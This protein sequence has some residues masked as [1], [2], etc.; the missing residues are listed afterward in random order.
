MQFWRQLLLSVTVRMDPYPFPPHVT[1]QHAHPFVHNLACN[2]QTSPLRRNG[3]ISCQIMPT[4][5]LF[6]F[7]FTCHDS[8][9]Q[10][11]RSISPTFPLCLVMTSFLGQSL[12][13]RL[14]IYISDVCSFSGQ[15]LLMILLFIVSLSF[16]TF[17]LWQ[18]GYLPS[19]PHH[20][21]LT[22]EGTHWTSI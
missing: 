17:H 10:N 16:Q 20:C 3:M 19:L 4:N 7:P 1:L 13:Y 2:P 12:R 18:Y 21:P 9:G 11:M 15:S 8:L 5:S 14:P 22:Q 6:L